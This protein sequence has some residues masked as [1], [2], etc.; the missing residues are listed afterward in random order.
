MKDHAQAKIN[1]IKAAIEFAEIVPL[2]SAFPLDDAELAFLKRLKRAVSE[3][4]EA[5]QSK[6]VDENG[7]EFD[8]LHGCG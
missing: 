5:K 2:K 1:L 4:K 6:R 3:Y 8:S 7:D